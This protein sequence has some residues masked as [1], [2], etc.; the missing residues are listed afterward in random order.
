MRATQAVLSNPQAQQGPRFHRIYRTLALTCEVSGHLVLRSVDL[1]FLY[2][3]IQGKG[4]DYRV[5]TRCQ[6]QV[7]SN[8]VG[9]TSLAEFAS[10]KSAH[11]FLEG[12][13]AK[14]L[15]AGMK[16]R[17]DERYAHYSLDPLER[18]WSFLTS[19]RRAKRTTNYAEF[20]AETGI[21]RCH[22][23]MRMLGE[24]N[25][26]YSMPQFKG[27]ITALVAKGKKYDPPRLGF[28]QC[29][30]KLGFDVPNDWVGMRA[31]WEAQRA[32][33]WAWPD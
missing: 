1:T 28:F 17:A 2:L 16:V 11:D 20:E 13:L 25:E 14:A 6:T 4:Q 24:L 33:C 8:M 19:V 26:R 15:L 5:V 7:G 32:A 30:K 3:G 22:E 12:E 23:A 10:W 18:A 9:T 31:F 29:A 27:L 21:H